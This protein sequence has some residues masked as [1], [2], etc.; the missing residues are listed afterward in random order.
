MKTPP[1]C[2]WRAAA[3]RALFARIRSAFDPSG[4]LNP[5]V[6]PRLARRP[7]ADVGDD[8]G[9]DVLCGREFGRAGGPVPGKKKWLSAGLPVET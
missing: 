7:I 5:N 8:V 1:G 6:L 9:V 2:R 4:T 3:E